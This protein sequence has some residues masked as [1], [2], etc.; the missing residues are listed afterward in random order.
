M[1]QNATK[2]LISVAGQPIAE[3][4]LAT[5]GDGAHRK[6]VANVELVG[7]LVLVQVEQ[8]G[9]RVGRVREAAAAS[10][11]FGPVGEIQRQVLKTKLYLRTCTARPKLARLDKIIKLGGDLEAG[12]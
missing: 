9:R 10:A 12:S 3:K 7:G 4:L 6:Q 1:P 5:K 11:S 8:V 2:W